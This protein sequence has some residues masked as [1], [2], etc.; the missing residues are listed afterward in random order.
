VQAGAG[1]GVHHRQ[2]RLL[3]GEVLQGGNQHRVLE[4][5]GVVARMEGVAVTE[6]AAMV[7]MPGVAVLRGMVVAAN[8]CR[9]RATAGTG[10]KRAFFVAEG[11]FL[12]SPTLE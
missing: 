8:A 11:L 12:L 3:F 5:V 1:M 4:H 9:T 2:R 7:T 6:H 10:R